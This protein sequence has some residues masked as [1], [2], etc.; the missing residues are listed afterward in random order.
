MLHDFDQPGGGEGFDEKVDAFFEQF[1]TI[2]ILRGEAAEVKHLEAAG[3]FAQ[4][5]GEGAAIG[6]VGQ[7]NV[8]EEEVNRRVGGFPDFPGFAGVGGLGALGS[9]VW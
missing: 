1:G 5:L 6:S 2:H 4:F 8:R 9:P 7:E 3:R